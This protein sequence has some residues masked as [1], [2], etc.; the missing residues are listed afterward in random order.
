MTTALALG[1]K[2]EWF[3]NSGFFQVWELAFA[4]ADCTVLRSDERAEV[5]RFRSKVET[6]EIWSGLVVNLEDEFPNNN[7]RLLWSRI[8]LETAQ[9][10]FL[11]EIGS[12]EETH[13]QV[14]AICNAIRMGNFFE[15]SLKMTEG[16][17]RMIVETR[18][19]SENNKAFEVVMEQMRREENDQNSE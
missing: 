17:R 14:S 4:Q 8:L 9:S 10:I 15:N 18:T 16:A 1:E 3:T 2:I 19:R 13:W 7:N 11:R 12:H 5:E 6:G